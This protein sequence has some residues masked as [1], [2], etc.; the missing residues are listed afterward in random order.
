M[1]LSFK[2][3]GTADIFFGRDS[4]ASR[5]VLPREL[6]RVAKKKLDWLNVAISLTSL[7]LP[8]LR[9]ERLKGK[10]AEQHSV[11]I[12]DQYRICFHWT[13]EGPEE[14]QIVDYH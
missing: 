12:N 7:G 2:D 9:L 10:R 11:R 5:R 4:A 8:G 6:H 1:I 14:V 13:T 3:R